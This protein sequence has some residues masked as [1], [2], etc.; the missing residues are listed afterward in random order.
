VYTMKNISM[1]TIRLAE[2]FF[3]A[4]EEKLVLSLLSEECGNNL[5]SMER[6]SDVELERVRFAAIKI[7]NGDI[8]MLKSAIELAKADWRD[9]LMQ[10]GFASGIKAHDIWY[11]S[12]LSK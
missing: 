10:A 9:L 12:I 3:T 5:P 2:K 6:Y 8:N 7:S 1:R 11:K 4:D